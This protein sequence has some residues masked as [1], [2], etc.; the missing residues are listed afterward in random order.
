MIYWLSR[1][2]KK[3]QINEFAHICKEYKSNKLKKKSI[4][5]WKEASWFLNSLQRTFLE[6]VSVVVKRRCKMTKNSSKFNTST[7]RCNQE[8]LAFS[9]Y[10]IAYILSIFIFAT[11][12]CTH[13]IEIDFEPYWINNTIFL[14]KTLILRTP[15]TIDFTNIIKE[16]LFKSHLKIL[17]R[18]YIKW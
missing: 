8:S 13:K 15:C 2:R 17:P 18:Q 16:F 4:N 11:H 9:L 1:S 12:K 3:L 10:Y 6:Q 7:P 5:T 14:K